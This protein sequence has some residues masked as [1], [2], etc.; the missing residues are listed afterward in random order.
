MCL[1]SAQEDTAA[2]A[3]ACKAIANQDRFARNNV[4]VL[5][6]HLKPSLLH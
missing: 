4:I 2:A 3:E 1:T 5:K 6:H